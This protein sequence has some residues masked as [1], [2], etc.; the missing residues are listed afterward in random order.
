MYSH[1]QI[2][3]EAIRTNRALQRMAWHGVQTSA[4]VLCVDMRPQDGWCQTDP[5]TQR[6]LRWTLK[7][8]IGTDSLEIV[9][10]S[11]DSQRR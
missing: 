1:C 10:V 11:E 9:D 8:T 2:Q 3:V 5:E 7:D 4:G 6:D